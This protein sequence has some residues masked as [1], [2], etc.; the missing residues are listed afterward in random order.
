MKVMPLSGA[1]RD[2]WSLAICSSGTSFPVC[3]LRSVALGKDRAERLREKQRHR[4]RRDGGGRRCPLHSVP[5]LRSVCG[6]QGCEGQP[7]SAVSPGDSTPAHHWPCLGHDL[8]PQLSAFPLALRL[9]PSMVL[10]VVGC[11]YS[12]STPFPF[13]S[14]FTSS[15]THPVPPRGFLAGSSS[16]SMGCDMLTSHPAGPVPAN[17]GRRCGCSPGVPPSWPGQAADG[18]EGQPGRGGPT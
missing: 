10:P 2:T 6:S 13:C 14:S 15:P 12:V 1:S 5:A 4:E 11:P 18:R 3:G 17:V 9:F 7:P 8:T 16:E